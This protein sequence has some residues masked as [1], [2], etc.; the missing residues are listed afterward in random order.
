MTEPV[1]IPYGYRV[2]T[3]QSQ[4]G[5]G[6]WN[7]VRFRKVRKGYPFAGDSGAIIIRRQEVVQTEMQVVAQVQVEEW[8]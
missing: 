8:E 3:G 5:D 1:K 4:K 6:I 7:G 2:V